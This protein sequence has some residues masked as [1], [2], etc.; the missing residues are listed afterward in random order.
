MQVLVV[1]GHQVVPAL[2]LD[3]LPQ[4]NLL[5]L[6]LSV[7]VDQEPLGMCLTEQYIESAVKDMHG[8]LVDV[9]KA[10]DHGIVLVILE[11][12]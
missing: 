10:L 12:R 8:T 3:K 7:L 5:L 9:L 1:V 11:G 4:W 2:H 6:H